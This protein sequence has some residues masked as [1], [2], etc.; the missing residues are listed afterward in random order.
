MNL[1]KIKVVV[2]NLFYSLLYKNFFKINRL[3][4]CNRHITNLSDVHVPRSETVN[5]TVI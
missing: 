4:I 5:L 1:S 2:E 3:A